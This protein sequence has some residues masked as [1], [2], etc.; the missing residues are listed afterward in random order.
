M[1]IKAEGPEEGRVQDSQSHAG[2]C[3]NQIYTMGQE[4]ADDEA[5]EEEESQE[6]AQDVQWDH[7]DG[8]SVRREASLAVPKLQ[9]LQS[10]SC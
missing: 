4:E 3:V 10:E 9:S 5:G 8:V 1:A 6:K 7:G 2:M